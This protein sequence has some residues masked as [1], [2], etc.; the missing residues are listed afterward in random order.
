MIKLCHPE[1]AGS[2]L[3]ASQQHQRL[4]LHS[5]PWVWAAQCH[6]PPFWFFYW[7]DIKIL[8]NTAEY[9]ILSKTETWC[10]K[11][12]SNWKV[13]CSKIRK[14]SSHNRL[15]LQTLSSKSLPHSAEGLDSNQ[16]LRCQFTGF[17]LIIPFT[18]HICH[19]CCVHH[20]SVLSSCFLFIT[21]DAAPNKMG[22]KVKEN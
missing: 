15:W 17:F 13:E 18:P 3:R 19:I 12:Y 1:L 11:W 20:V 4:S 22:E 14:C 21:E 9:P 8:Y 5:E 10:Y 6:L 2:L 16:E 7:H